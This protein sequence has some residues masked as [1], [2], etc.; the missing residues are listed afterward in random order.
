MAQYTT[1]FFANMFF[2]ILI[3]NVISMYRSVRLLINFVTCN[4]T[5]YP[6]TTSP[7]A[8][9]RGVGKFCKSSMTS[10]NLQSLHY[11][12]TCWC[13]T[14]APVFVC[15]CL[16][17]TLSAISPSAAALLWW[18]WQD[19]SQHSHSGG[20]APL[21]RFWPGHPVSLTH[22]YT[23]QEVR[24]PGKHLNYIF[25]CIHIPEIS[26]LLVTKP[27]IRYYSILCWFEL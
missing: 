23:D 19:G 4:F 14:F 15:A 6:C 27:L 2:R 20:A 7:S 17:P 18:W 12:Y 1:N 16:Y 11:L 13:E 3:F 10:E 24:M 22:A 5:A 25:G 9:S 26:C 8:H 21:R